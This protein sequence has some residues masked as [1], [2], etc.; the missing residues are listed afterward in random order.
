M[1][2]ATERGYLTATDLA[3]YLVERG[4]PFRTAHGIVAGIV[5]V[6]MERGIAL[7]GLSLDELRGFDDAFG[8][9]VYEVL[10]PRRSIERRSSQGGTATLQ[11]RGA[12]EEA[13]REIL[14]MKTSIAEGESR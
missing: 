6:C 13:R 4:R 8:E 1:E 7:T 3:D 14:Q 11:V 5:Q 9:D 2:R 10:D 12:L